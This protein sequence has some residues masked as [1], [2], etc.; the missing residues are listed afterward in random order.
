MIFKIAIF[1]YRVKK[2]GEVCAEAYLQLLRLVHDI[3]LK[4]SLA[5]KDKL[6]DCS[7]KVADALSGIVKVASELKHGA[8]FVDMT[9]PQV[10]AEQELLAAAVAIEAA[11]KKLSELTIQKEIVSFHM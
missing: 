6:P 10:R 3:I 4:P 5:Q 2:C 11:A 8:G 9:D 1:H 7:K